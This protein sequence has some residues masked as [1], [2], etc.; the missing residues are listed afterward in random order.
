MLK[1]GEV[2]RAESDLL[3]AY[4]LQTTQLVNKS[5]IAVDWEQA[6]GV[7]QAVEWKALRPLLLVDVYFGLKHA[8][9]DTALIVR[10]VT[11]LVEYPTCMDMWYEGVYTLKADGEIAEVIKAT[12]IEQVVRAAL[13]GGITTA[14]RYSDAVVAA[15]EGGEYDA[16][17]AGEE[18]QVDA[19]GILR[20]HMGV[21]QRF[22]R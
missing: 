11:S 12:G 1:C 9:L 6:C 18:A 4:V 15:L 22:G 10:H 17:D 16:L 21:R 7:L 14:S 3:R 13:I 5:D 2:Y 8:Q 19:G 20:R